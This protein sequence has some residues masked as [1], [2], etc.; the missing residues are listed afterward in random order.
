M[1]FGLTNAPTTFVVA[2]IDDILV[3]S[4]SKNE[5]A[6]HLRMV[7]NV[8]REHRLYAKLSN[9]EFWLERVSFL[10]HLMSQEGILVDRAR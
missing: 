1:P 3:Y 8:L 7:L 4:K 2:F 10:R 9:C 6:I 5:H